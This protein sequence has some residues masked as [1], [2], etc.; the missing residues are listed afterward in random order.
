VPR[1]SVL[2][3]W[4]EYY[5]ILHDTVPPI[6]PTSPTRKELATLFTFS[7]HRSCTDL[8]QK[9]RA[10][11]VLQTRTSS[12]DIKLTAFNALISSKTRIQ[13][14]MRL[15]LDTAHHAHLRQL[16]RELAASPSQVRDELRQL[17]EAG[18]LLSRQEGRQLVYRA[19]AAHPMFPEL[20]SMV[21]KALGMDRILDSIVRR[22]GDLEQAILID[23]YA[24]GRDT[25]LVDLILVGDINQQNLL[26]LVAKTERYVNRKIR[27]LVLTSKEF[28]ALS[29]TLSVRPQL[30]LWSRDTPATINTASHDPPKDAE[31]QDPSD[32]P[33]R[34]PSKGLPDAPVQAPSTIGSEA[35]PSASQVHRDLMA[36]DA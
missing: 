31:T 16:A 3:D 29:P 7:D 17:S 14:L 9:A 36:E 26:D 6:P 24:Q 5:P 32:T 28:A 10:Y 34:D 27:T 25:G 15:F 23:D 20:R 21:H 2:R 11:I 4:Q 35:S 1:A 22:L 19:N 18:L 30:T 12:S 8:P 13:I 33:D